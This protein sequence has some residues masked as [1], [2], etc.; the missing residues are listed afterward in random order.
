MTLPGREP[1][2][3]CAGTSQ[4]PGAVTLLLVP[5]ASVL[6]AS[7]HP[8]RLD[9]H[10]LQPRCQ[11]GCLALQGNWETSLPTCASSCPCA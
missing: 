11:V 2:L 10:Q 8:K 9:V 5:S 1:H 7:A 3:A 6:P 4:L